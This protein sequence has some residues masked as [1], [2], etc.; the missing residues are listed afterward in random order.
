MRALVFVAA[1]M[2]AFATCLSLA[3]SQEKNSAGPSEETV[4]FDDV[5]ISG[6]VVDSN[7]A[8][9]GGV[10]I[11]TRVIDPTWPERFRRAVTCLS[12]ERGRFKLTVHRRS[13]IDLTIIAATADGKMQVALPA[14]F[15]NEPNGEYWEAVSLRLAPAKEV[16][17]KVVNSDQQ[18]V[19]GAKVWV[20]L[21][22][23]FLSPKVSETNAEGIATFQLP[24][25]VAP[26]VV[27]AFQEGAGLDYS[28][29]VSKRAGD[30][31]EDGASEFTLQLGK[32]VEI[33]IRVISEGEKAVSGAKVVASFRRPGKEALQFRG[34]LWPEFLTRRTDEKGQASVLAPGDATEPVVFGAHREGF[35]QAQRPSRRFENGGSRPMGYL[36]DPAKPTSVTIAMRE[37]AG[38]FITF[39]GRVVDAKG[40]PIGGA[41]IDATGQGANPAISNHS[42]VAISDVNGEFSME[43]VRGTLYLLFTECA[44]RRTSQQSVYIGE[45]APKGP[46]TITA[47]PSKSVKIRVI[48]VATLEWA[49]GARVSMMLTDNAEY[50]RRFMMPVE[51]PNA[52]AFALANSTPLFMSIVA[53]AF[54]DE[55]GVATFQL[56]AGDYEALAFADDRGQIQLPLTISRDAE[57]VA[58]DVFTNSRGFGR[59]APLTSP[60]RLTF[61][62]SKGN[63]VQ[64]T[65]YLGSRLGGF[66]QSVE[67]TSDANGQLEL[68]R[69]ARLTLIRA[70]S[71]DDSLVATQEIKV[72]DQDVKIVLQPGGVIKGRLVDAELKTPMKD[73]FLEL[74]G[75]ENGRSPGSKPIATSKTN[76]DGQFE[77]SGVVANQECKIWLKVPG[78]RGFM[79]KRIYFFARLD[80]PGQ[81][82]D[83]EDVLVAPNQ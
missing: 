65:V 32:T 54:T 69:D 72:S 17:A 8:P 58:T 18:P 42:A 64:S 80:R 14:P 20:D 12:D 70:K 67:E 35:Q 63:P 41:F 48:D 30:P 6:T 81:V 25:G 9:V 11:S 61:V 75:T 21:G 2:I 33:P 27:V 50:H 1:K 79:M 40:L 60:L 46:L 45:E 44:D 56:P 82:L 7:E 68:S 16:I 71:L 39:K 29:Q 38:A 28:P 73:E 51:G 49:P 26:R 19:R 43:L 55:K 31:A 4:R 77:F 15:G 36:W 78:P 5:E 13:V 37:T 10:E 66:V 23:N 52:G 34:N 53:T 74:H 76:A 3:I 59:L 62:D 47:M 57:S 24:S 83:L 22:S